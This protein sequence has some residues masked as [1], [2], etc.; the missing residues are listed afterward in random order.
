[1]RRFPV[2]IIVSVIAHAV[3]LVWAVPEKHAPAGASAA[4]GGASDEPLS[5]VLLDDD[6]GG[7]AA[8][9]AGAAVPDITVH[10]GS[11][12]TIA[13][14][15]AGRRETPGPATKP[16]GTTGTGRGPTHS[17]LMRMRKP[18]LDVPLSGEFL[19]TFLRNSKPRPPP[20]LLPEERIAEELK[21][22]RKNHDWERVVALNDE[23]NRLD[24]E[25]SGGGTY[26][27]DKPGF[28][29][30]VERDGTIH[31]RD[32]RTFDATDAIMRVYGVDPYAA[33]KLRLLDRT[34]DQR[35]LIGKRYRHDQLSRAAELMQNNI[36]RMWLA[37]RDLAARKQALF[38]LWDDCAETGDDDLVA[39]AKGARE[40]VLGVIRSRLT[41]ADA[42]TPDELARLNAKRTS[43]EVFA[44]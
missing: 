19:E 43:R 14:G 11:E 13:T 36:D 17:P 21:Q 7:S 41:G 3:A 24:L 32:K 44:P 33:E 34:R 37:T 1:V 25:P 42:Y 5:V 2:A 40:L 9:G 18:G 35:A 29:A 15:Q 22:A 10:P 30:T 6:S 31:L 4:A 26:R 12:V 39:G 38:E 23:K 27:A 16:S 20:E 8:G 28:G